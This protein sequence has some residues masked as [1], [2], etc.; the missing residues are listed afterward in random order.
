VT[1]ITLGACSSSTG[2]KALDYGSCTQAQQDSVVAIEGQPKAKLQPTPG[3]A[4]VNWDYSN[5][6]PFFVDFDGRT[7][8][9][10]VTTIFT[11]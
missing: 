5:L 2:P 6:G 8:S 9:C 4:V 10:H 7:A 11:S 1:A 3:V